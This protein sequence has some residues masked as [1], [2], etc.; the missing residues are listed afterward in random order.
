MAFPFFAGTTILAVWQ[1]L[2]RLKRSPSRR[3]LNFCSKMKHHK[4]ICVTE[5]RYTLWCHKSVIGYHLTIVMRAFVWVLI[6]G[7]FADVNFISGFVDVNMK[8]EDDVWCITD[9]WKAA[10][11]NVIVSILITHVNLSQWTF[12]SVYA[13]KNSQQGKTTWKRNPHG[14]WAFVTYCFVKIFHVCHRKSSFSSLFNVIQIIKNGDVP[15]RDTNTVNV[16]S[17]I[18]T[19]QIVRSI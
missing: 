6:K 5:L 2:F 12:T 19:R 13:R 18:L 7:T 10:R 3:S 4:R 1:Y 16:S 17:T 11:L 14:L 9:V 8:S 15:A